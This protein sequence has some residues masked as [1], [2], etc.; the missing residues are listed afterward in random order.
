MNMNS[1]NPKKNITTRHV[2]NSMTE[3]VI[4][5]TLIGSDIIQAVP[6]SVKMQNAPK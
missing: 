4:Q 2:T 3:K 1:K 5:S 6:E